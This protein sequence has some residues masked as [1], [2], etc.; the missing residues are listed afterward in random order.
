MRSYL[1]EDI[2]N[3]DAQKIE[4]ALKGKGFSGPM[5]GLY[6]LPVPDGMLQEMQ[7]EHLPE[8][9]PYMMALEV[10][11]G[12]EN[13]HL[14]LELLVRARNTLRCDCMAYAGAE[15]RAHMIEFLDK[16]IREQD[17]SV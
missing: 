4:G 8:C 13:A 17:V 14:K 15:L 6:Y 5:D 1:V 9:G 3:S 7:V 2:I 12:I 16:F 11:Y 10:N